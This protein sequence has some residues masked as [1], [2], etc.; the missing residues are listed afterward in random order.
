MS[1]TVELIEDLTTWQRY[2]RQWDALTRSVP[3]R[4]FAWLSSWW[5]E[6]GP[7]AG[8]QWPRLCVLAVHDGQGEPVGFAPWYVGRSIS[9][10][11]VL[12]PLGTGE[13]YSDYLSLLT[14]PDN[15]QAVAAALADWLC[16]DGDGQWDIIDLTGIDAQDEA[17]QLLVEELSS[18]GLDVQCREGLNTWRLQLPAT[19]DEYLAQRSKSHRKKIRR[20]EK[21]CLDNSQM[22][23]H[24]VRTPADAL[25][26]FQQL[27][28]LHQK[29]WRALGRPGCFA[30][31]RFTGFLA[32]VT[33]KLLA[34]DRLRLVWL[35][36][37]GAPLTA[38]FMLIGD[39]VLYL[40]QGGIDPQRLDLEPGRLGLIVYI[41]Q[42]IA[43]GFRAVDLLRGNEPYKA[44]FGAEPRPTA[45]IRVV[46]DRV[47]A[48]LR[49]QAWRIGHGAK[50]LIKRAM[51]AARAL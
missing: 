38:D 47:S 32:S 14:L 18:R 10:G 48:R 4:S 46:S 36:Y 15:Q 41:K 39:G 43:D 2:A 7:P 26:G 12:A 11:K 25:I 33:P 1:L 8:S 22:R 31:P 37:E 20:L 19:W 28:D 44:H 24:E 23:V 17:T 9:T 27:V 29:R 30:S 13:T 5:E 21:N 6:Y 51:V 50:Q 40:Y 49:N 35:E 3:F 34:E 42:A 16:G 45:E